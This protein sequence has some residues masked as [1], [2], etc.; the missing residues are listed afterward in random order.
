[1]KETERSAATI[2]LSLHDYVRALSLRYAPIPDISEDI[3]QQVFLEFVSKSHLWNLDEDVRPLLRVLTKRFADR[4]IHEKKRTMPETLMKIA[5]NTIRRQEEAF[6]EDKSDDNLYQEEKQAL[7]I[8]IDSL[9]ARSKEMIELRFFKNETIDQIAKK[10]SLSTVA[11]RHA[12]YRIRDKLGKCIAR[13]VQKNS[14][15]R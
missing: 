12:I 9:P 10:L 3:C 13:K 1:M 5:E 11:V 14:G 4:A 15:Y 8:C 2:F 7:K 6:P